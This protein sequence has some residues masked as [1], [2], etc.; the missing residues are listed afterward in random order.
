MH[1]KI[2]NFSAPPG[3]KKEEPHQVTQSFGVHPKSH[4]TLSKS[5]KILTHNLEWTNSTNLRLYCQKLA[6]NNVDV[7]LIQGTRWQ[8]SGQMQFE[9]YCVYHEGVGSKGPSAHGG[10]GI[11]LKKEN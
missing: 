3:G 6:K 7:A 4:S 9:G 11:L 8:Y 10:V 1:S 2:T 5:L